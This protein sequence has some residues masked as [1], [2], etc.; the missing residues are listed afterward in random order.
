[1]GGVPREEAVARA[2]RAFD[3]VLAGLLESTGG[4]G[5]RS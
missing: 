4:S 2:H 3:Q 5:Q 1:M